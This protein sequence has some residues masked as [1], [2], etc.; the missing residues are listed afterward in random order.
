MLCL[1]RDSWRED[2]QEHEAVTRVPHA[3][4]PTWTQHAPNEEHP[5]RMAKGKRKQIPTWSPHVIEIFMFS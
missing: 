5:T 2:A 4:D 3:I 1:P